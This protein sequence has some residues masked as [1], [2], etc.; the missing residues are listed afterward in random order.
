MGKSGR[1]AYIQ[2]IMELNGKVDALRD[3]LAIYDSIYMGIY[4]V[5]KTADGCESGAKRAVNRAMA[6]AYLQWQEDEKI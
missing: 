3:E 2:E 4:E 5:L 1:E 6:D